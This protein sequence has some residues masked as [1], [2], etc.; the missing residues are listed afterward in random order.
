VHHWKIVFRR[1]K[2]LFEI[3][4]IS[5][6]ILSS[7]IYFLIKN[8]RTKNSNESNGSYPSNYDNI[9]DETTYNKDHLF[10]LFR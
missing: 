6:L 4:F 10:F 7:K 5:K 8:T 3:D 1:K 2:Y 9:D